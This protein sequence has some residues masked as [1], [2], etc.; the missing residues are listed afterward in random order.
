MSTHKN[1]IVTL[2]KKMLL[3]IYIITNS[4]LF[5]IFYEIIELFHKILTNI[6]S[7]FF[8]LPLPSSL[9]LPL[10][11]NKKLMSNIYQYILNDVMAKKYYLGTAEKYCCY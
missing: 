6:S 10:L 1:E 2:K 7:L 5:F 8:S 4:V 3:L 9:S 11:S